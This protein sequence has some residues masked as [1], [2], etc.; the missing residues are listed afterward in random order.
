M[1]D[2]EFSLCADGKGRGAD[3]QRYEGT[4]LSIYLD[5][6]LARIAEPTEADESSGIAVRFLHAICYEPTTLLPKEKI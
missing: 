5:G 2:L 3:I 6:G 4:H 1:C